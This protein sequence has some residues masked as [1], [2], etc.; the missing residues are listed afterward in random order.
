MT[1]EEQLTQEEQQVLEEAMKSYGSPTQE[2]K[3]SIHTFLNKVSTSGDTT[4][5]GY[6]KDEELGCTL[7]SLRTYK[8]LEL[9][10]DELCNDEI[11]A[12]YFK[13]KAE[14]LSASSLSRDAK[15]I[16]LAV[17]Q[18]REIADVTEKPRAENKGWFKKKSQG[19]QNQM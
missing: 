1:E 10:S 6:L 3:H 12:R 11:W 14:I 15:L 16:T 17:L 7:Y 13:K 8:S 9:D 18:K 5:T 19:G 2:E 4:K